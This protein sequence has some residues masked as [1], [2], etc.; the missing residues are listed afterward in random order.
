MLWMRF[1]ATT[2]LA[3][4][5]TRPSVSRSFRSLGAVT[6]LS[7]ASSLAQ[8]SKATTCQMS[9]DTTAESLANAPQEKY[10][11]DYTAPP[12]WTKEVDMNVALSS[13]GVATVT[14][15]IT[16]ERADGNQDEDFV[17]DGEAMV[18]NSISIDGSALDAS[19]YEVTDEQLI[20]KA[21]TLAGKDRFTLDTDVTPIKPEDNTELSG[22]YRSDSMYCTQCEAEGFRRITYFQD[23]PD[24]MAV[25]KVRIEAD[26]DSCPVLLSNG[27]LMEEGDLAD[28]RHFAVWSDP[29]PKPSYLFA[30]IAG[31]LGS[32]K[33][34]YTTGSGRKVLLQFFSEHENVQQLEYAMESLKRAMAWDEETFGL[35]Y[36]LDLYSVVAV[37]SFNMGAM[38]NTGCNVFNT[39]LVLASPSTATD[40][41]Y[42][43]I[44]GVIGHEYFHN[45]TGNRV[46][47]RDWF[48]LTLKEGLTVY[49]DQTFSADVGSS[50]AVKRIEDVA[51]LR[52]R[53]FSEDAGP[54]AHPIRPDAVMAIDNF[55][56][57]T[58]YQKGAEVIRMYATL[59]G[60]DGFRKGMDLYFQ[61]HTGEA[62]TCDDFRA[63][64]ADANGRD[65]TQFERWYSQAGTPV[66]SASR[67]D[68][69]AAGVYKLRLAQRCPST[70][71]QESSSKE[72]FHIPVA[73]GL[74]GPG[75]EVMATR[76]LELTEAEQVFELPL[77]DGVDADDVVPSVL[78]GFSAP[79]RLEMTQSD[80][81]LAF[82]AA[83][84]TDEFNKWEAG[85][86]LG[87]RVVLRLVD[88][89]DA[90]AAK[91]VEGFALLSS[92][93][94]AT[95]GAAAD[96]TLN[97]SLAAYALALPEIAALV[98]EVAASGSLVDPIKIANA[99]GAVKKA[100]AE[101]HK[102]ALAALYGALAPPA[103]AAQT[104]DVSPAAIS[105]RR[106]RNF[107]LDMLCA[108]ED[109]AALRRSNEQFE[110]ATCM[111][112]KLAA[113]AKLA[114]IGGADA[115]KALQKF[116]ADAEGDDLVVNKWF[117]I[118]AA[119]D[120][121]DALDK[122]KGLMEHPDFT[123]ANPN[124]MRSLV[125]GFVG[126]TKAF[127]AEDGAG[128][129]FLGDIIAELNVKNPQMA[130]RMAGPLSTYR[131]FDE[132]RQALMR[133]QLE[134]LAAMPEISKDLAEVLS[135]SLGA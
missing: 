30:V 26:K 76:V 39:A 15:S 10:R 81:Q 29:Y 60:K 77:P 23:R 36:H 79:V 124:R 125:G 122:V 11:L 96:G 20:I 37:S 61:R 58:V 113:A 8:R 9:T 24:V 28:G 43:R 115:E 6:Q 14:T 129:A 80:E 99:R 53:Q 123:L 133:A 48:Q 93:F 134:R 22:L 75:G 3:A 40:L 132:G 42:E 66:V 2:A 45:W 19:A 49:R 69:G 21:S 13:D 119:A 67:A 71:G 117:S 51:G 89:A 63:A 112:E 102:E 82:L 32:I 54:L 83:E 34:E 105:R 106:L 130:A 33:S 68:G 127:H 110:G 65:L 97:L 114:S 94:A 38:E 85:Q 70:P 16:V 52:G 18:L 17:L 86:R 101:E 4:A 27:N 109:D 41:N 91:D 56:T 128:Y 135:R 118:Q 116:Y 59:L 46:T 72:P 131:R 12:F 25:Y 73:V 74:L 100:L 121:D 120:A 64:M 95:L 111:T 35:E 108:L 107:C 92:A 84:D 50:H 103:D 78:R 87:Q 90:P 98:D 1:L 31:D 7:F 88:A 126:N 62:V 55:Y 104:F 57:S 47:C 44:E 5:F